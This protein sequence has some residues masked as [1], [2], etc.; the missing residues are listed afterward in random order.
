MSCDQCGESL[1]LYALGVLE[2]SEANAVAEH[3]AT[4]CPACLANLR[5]ALEQNALLS[6]NVP[7]VDP[8]ARLRRRVMDA[9]ALPSAPKRQWLPW[10]V[11]LAALVALVA[12]L[13]IQ[14]RSRSAE[15]EIAQL[16]AA[17]QARVSSM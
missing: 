3:L 14:S 16:K 1:E 5:S 12:G 11:A 9:V 4:G 10:A 17:D 13:T 6:E 2:I 7:L 8:P 15:S